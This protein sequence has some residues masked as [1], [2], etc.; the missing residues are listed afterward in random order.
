[1]RPSI[2]HY[3]IFYRSAI[4]RIALC[5]ISSDYLKNIVTLKSWLGVTDCNTDNGTIGK[6]RTSKT[7]YHD[8]HAAVHRNAA[9]VE[10]VRAFDHKNFMMISQAVQKMMYMAHTDQTRSH[11]QPGSNSSPLTLRRHHRLRGN[12]T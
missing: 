6:T 3:M 9:I 1:M 4:I 7:L 11:N 10:V 2:D 8:P 12:I 5:C